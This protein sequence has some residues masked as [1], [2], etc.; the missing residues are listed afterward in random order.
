MALNH[1][2]AGG[3]YWQSQYGT[4]TKAILWKTPDGL[5]SL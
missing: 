3:D 5:T 1:L 2:V 4:L